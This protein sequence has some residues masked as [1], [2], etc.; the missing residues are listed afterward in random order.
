[1]PSHTPLLLCPKS[2]LRARL[3]LPLLLL[4]LLL[5]STIPP[6]TTPPPSRA[7][8]SLVCLSPAPLLLAT[9]LPHACR[10]LSADLLP[11]GSGGRA[12]AR[13]PDQRRIRTSAPGI[14]PHPL[15]STA[16]A[17]AVVSKPVVWL[18]YA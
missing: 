10:L 17:L 16:S 2:M 4:L 7:S 14:P 1:M 6:S 18:W 12:A 3:L 13:A 8:H 5:P 11:T 9:H 15:P